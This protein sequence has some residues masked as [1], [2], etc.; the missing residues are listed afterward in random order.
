MFDKRIVNG[1][2]YQGGMFEQT[3]IYINKETIALV[4][5]AFY[6]AKETIDASGMKV[7][8]GLID[9]HVHFALDLGKT[10]S[11]DD[12]QNGSR[13]ASFGGV[14]TFIDF[15]DPVDNEKDLVHAFERRL[16]EAGD[17]VIDY[18]FHATIKQ[19]KCDLETF[20]LTMKELGLSSL[21]LFTTYSDSG[22]KTDDESIFELLRLSRK[23]GILILAHVE[24]DELIRLDDAFTYR[25]LSISRPSQS[26]QM[27]AMKLAEFVRKTKGSLYMVHCSSGKTVKAL[28]DNYSDILHKHMF[29]E[30]CPHYFNLTN[31]CLMQE[32]GY[33]YTMAPPLRSLAEKELLKRL[34]HEI[35]TI[36]TDHCPFME[37]EKNHLMLKDIPLGIGSIE[38]SFELMHPILQTKLV[39][40]MSM[41]P[42]KIF[43]LDHSKGSIERGKDAD[44]FLFEEQKDAII[45]KSHSKSDV[46][47]FEG[48]PTDGVIRCTM[49]RGRVI[50]Q[51]GVFLGGKGIYLG[52]RVQS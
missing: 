19:P 45:R 5:D 47:L 16:E 27:E 39:E 1:L 23:H 22:R 2:V 3:N 4:S 51:D 37:Q 42:A 9:P 46:D 41:N 20:L 44:L 48:R 7:F 35:D 26:E 17:S 15:L 12:F 50:V 52:K 49:S 30:S 28:V 24:N 21:K 29:L 14:T 31:D 36:G 43:G 6:D 8:P 40:K 13:S 38:H 18:R 25:A 11:A 34:S 32:N 33:L 10:T